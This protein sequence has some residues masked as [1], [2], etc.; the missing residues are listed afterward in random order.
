METNMLHR[1]TC[2][3]DVN[4]RKLMDIYTES[5]YEN[6]E[7]FYPDERDKEKAVKKVEVSFLDYLKSEFLTR[8]E[9]TCWVLEENSIWCSALRTIRI[10]PG[11]FYL[12]ALETRPDHRQDGCAS[13][14]LSGVLDSLKQEGPFHLC[15]CVSKK[16]IASLKAHEKSGFRIVSETGYDY[17]NKEE[18][19][20]D[21][22]L[23]Y[24][25]N[26]E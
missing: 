18:N 9:N 26:G 25:Y 16:N 6:T 20:Q 23:E 11:L 15:A 12:E 7:Y 22:G 13:R 3:S 14:I 8:P 4:E 17:L 24:H 5:N 10:Q 19:E 2:F 1:I 21:Y